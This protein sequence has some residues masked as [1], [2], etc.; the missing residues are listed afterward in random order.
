M[1]LEDTNIVAAF[2][3][4]LGRLGALP[5]GIFNWS[6]EDARQVACGIVRA[7][8][9]TEQR[10]IIALINETID[11]FSGRNEDKAAVLRGLLDDLAD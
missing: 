5:M 3:A 4:E 8:V 2:Y 10:R 9:A 11:R 1:T 6:E 7:T